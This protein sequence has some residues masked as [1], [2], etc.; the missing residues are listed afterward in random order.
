[1]SLSVRR[2]E[3]LISTDLELLLKKVPEGMLFYREHNLR[4]QPE[5]LMFLLE[6][7]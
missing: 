7:L 3:L 5:F 4:H 1:M 2:E 6:E